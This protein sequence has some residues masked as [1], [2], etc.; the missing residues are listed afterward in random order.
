VFVVLLFGGVYLILE[1][2]GADAA[3]RNASFDPLSVM[4]LI[5]VIWQSTGLGIARVHMLMRQL[6]LERSEA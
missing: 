6:D 4:V 1:Q 5:A 2:F 3:A